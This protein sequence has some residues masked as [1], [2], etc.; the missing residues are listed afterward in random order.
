MRKNRFFAASGTALMIGAGIFLLMKREPEKYSDK[1][2][3]TLSREEL[4]VEREKI[5]KQWGSTGGDYSLGVR[6]QNLLYRFNDEMRLRDYGDLKR[7]EHKYPPH[8]EH[9]WNL[10]KPD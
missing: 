6:L 1:W 8:R 4:D 10:Y 5:Q 7:E 2:F 3:Q 9:G